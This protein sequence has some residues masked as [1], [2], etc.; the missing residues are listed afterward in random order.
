MTVENVSMVVKVEGTSKKISASCR[1][2]IPHFQIRSGATG[3]ICCDWIFKLTFK[4][5]SK[6]ISYTKCMLIVKREVMLPGIQRTP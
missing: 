3:A 1:T 5:K 2:G 6:S 4:L